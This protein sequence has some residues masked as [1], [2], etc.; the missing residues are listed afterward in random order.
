MNVG[1]GTS[2]YLFADEDIVRNRCIARSRAKSL[3]EPVFKQCC[4]P[5][6]SRHYCTM[7]WKKAKFTGD[8][9]K[10][11]NWDP[12]TKHS[13]LPALELLDGQKEAKRR[14]EAALRRGDG[15]EPGLRWE[16]RKRREHDLRLQKPFVSLDPSTKGSVSSGAMSP[17]RCHRT[18]VC[19]ATLTSQ[20]K[21]IGWRTLMP[22]TMASASTGSACFIWHRSLAAMA[23]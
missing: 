8:M 16:K 3:L 10:Y 21:A 22:T 19:S 15:D 18:P 20:P 23:I 5:L 14:Y 1:A 11:G 4:R 6:N 17:W 9:W 2:R 13:S 7:H 12:D